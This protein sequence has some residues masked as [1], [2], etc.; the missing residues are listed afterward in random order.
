M[1]M[2]PFIQSGGAKKNPERPLGS[3]EAV[4]LWFVQRN[5]FQVGNFIPEATLGRDS[6]KWNRRRGFGK[7]VSTRRVKPEGMLFPDHALVV[8]VHDPDA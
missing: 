7:P 5:Q 1:E 8:L 2:I 3:C 6:F 4:A